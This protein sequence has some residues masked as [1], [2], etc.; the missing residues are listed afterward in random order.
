M[1]DIKM[2]P[3]LVDANP[4]LAFSEGPV[5]RSIDELMQG[6]IPSETV[7]AVAGCEVVFANYDVLQH[8]FP[9]LRLE[10][11]EKVHPELTLL[12]GRAKE[13][14]VKE[15]IDEWLIR[16]TCYV[17]ENQASQDMVNTEI[18]L[19][20]KTV[21]AYR[22]ALYGRALVF[23]LEKNYEGL[24]MDP[25]E[26]APEG[27]GLLD[28][29][30]TGLEAGKEHRYYDHGNGLL[31][32]SE[33][34]VEY[35][36]QQLIE[37]IFRHSGSQFETLPTYAIIKLGFEVKN[38]VGSAGPAGLMV[39][40]AQR[41]P[42][43][44]GGLPEYQSDMQ[45]LHLEIE[46]L[47]R[48]YGVTSTTYVTSV[49]LW[50]D[51]DDGRMRVS[52]GDKEVHNLSDEQIENLK[53]VSHFTGEPMTFEGV[54]IQH[55]REYS[56]DPWKAVMIDF[57]TFRVLEKFE[58]PILSLV[59]D[60]LMR[61]GGSIW[62]DF[63]IYRQPDLKLVVPFELWGDETEF[64]GFPTT[65]RHTKQRIL[66]VGVANYLQEGKFNR[67]DVM[68]IL[69]AYLSTATSRWD[70]GDEESEETK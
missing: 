31:T 23:S 69:H 36:N 4:N 59:M 46:L 1:I 49:K 14:M 29:K 62:P 26:L 63:E 5:L 27:N 13:L 38:A 50:A 42:E 43:N 56:R 17:S 34:F 41:R 70:W 12:S 19:T 37:S 68:N 33:A 58:H 55:T 10:R 18:K 15:R 22:P 25:A 24:G 52:Y 11:L 20:G 7:H 9:C 61:W 44:P 2:P 6:D 66:C 16:H 30:G 65:L 8:D 28:V 54:N 48:R 60:K 64:W 35:V 3:Q 53:E 32:L 51:P 40:R 21:E 45:L 47:L 39:R 67:Q 57:G